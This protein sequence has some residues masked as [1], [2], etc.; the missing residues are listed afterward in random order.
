MTSFFFSGKN[1]A[2]WAQKLKSSDFQLLCPN[3]AR[4][5]VTQ[6]ADCHLAQVPAQAVMV[7]PDVNVFALYGL[8][9]RA[10]VLIIHLFLG[11][12]IYS[13]TQ[14]KDKDNRT[15]LPYSAS[16]HWQN[17]HSAQ[18]CWKCGEKVKYSTCNSPSKTSLVHKGFQLFAQPLVAVV[19]CWSLRCF[20]MA[21]PCFCV[22]PM[23]LHS[24]IFLGMQ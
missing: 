22:V 7:H 4:A 10:Q 5:E 12:V 15:T 21:V 23:L 16:W 6:F 19:I 1:S 9:D 2:S 3:G 24:G 17:V 11:G 14:S 8:L 13:L 18:P 20:L